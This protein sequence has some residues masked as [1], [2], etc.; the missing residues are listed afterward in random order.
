[1]VDELFA[2]GAEQDRHAEPVIKSQGGHDGDVVVQVLAEADAGIGDELRLGDA[3][4]NAGIDPLFEEVEHVEHHV[5]VLRIVVH[6]LGV[7]LGVHQDHR[8]PGLGRDGERSRVM[9]QGRDIVEDI[10]ARGRARGA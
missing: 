8:Q 4:R 3:R 1:M 10:G 2:R 6:G 7:A 5:A 9:R